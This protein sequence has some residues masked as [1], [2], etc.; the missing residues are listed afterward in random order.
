M[1]AIAP[2]A[3]RLQRRRSR[4]A[5]LAH[6]ALHLKAGRKQHKKKT[7]ERPG[8]PH[9]SAG[10]F[11]FR[12]KRSLCA[13]IKEVALCGSAQSDLFN[14]LRQRVDT[15]DSLPFAG[16][17]LRH[18]FYMPYLTALAVG[19]RQL[20][21][22]PMFRPYGTWP[23]ATFCSPLSRPRPNPVNQSCESC[24]RHFFSRRDNEEKHCWLEKIPRLGKHTRSGIVDI[25]RHHL[26]RSV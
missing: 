7:L 8:I 16:P 22:L 21:A 26:A 25:D 2:I 24:F 11:C 1:V 12:L 17:R 9:E 3:S 4:C 15:S 19:W 20:S 18:V 6:Q 5:L 10:F 23:P 14:P 13:V